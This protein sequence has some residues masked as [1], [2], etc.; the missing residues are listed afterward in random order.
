MNQS[1]PHWICGAAE[2]DITPEGSVF[3]FGYPHVPRMST[4]V[5][6]PLLSSAIYCSDGQAGVMLIANDIIWVPRSVSLRARQR[7]SESTGIPVSNIM[8]TASHTH[9]GPVATQM[10]SHSADTVVPP[11]DPQYLQHLEDR[12]VEAGIAAF[13]NARPATL[14]MAIA[15]ATGL[16]TNRHDPAGPANPKLPVLVARDAAKGDLIAIMC[17]CSMHP[18]V[19]HEDWLLISGDFPGL[20]RRQLR[21]RGFGCPFVYHMGAAGDQSPRHVVRG[22]TIAEAV[23]LGT[24]LA[25][26]I[27]GALDAAA[28]VEPIRIDCRSAKVE[29]P[30]R[31][32][33]SLQ[34]A[35]ELEAAA[36]RTWESLKASGASPADIRTAECAVFGAEETVTL[37]RAAGEGLLQQTAAECMPAEV[38]ALTIGDHTWV[39]W[40]GEVFVAFALEVMASH[41]NASVITLANGE[42]QGYLVTQA[43][44]DTHTYEAG[45]A[46]F[47]SPDG[48]Q[49]LVQTTRQLLS[50]RPT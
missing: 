42:L 28:P 6:D 48:G 1:A 5:H 9:S 46:L 26:R 11:P 36:R 39:G 23:R 7:I 44:I 13:R 35:L 21:Q 29:L 10:L 8:V 33:P 37:A 32:I 16:G 14:G 30:V 2:A 15:D 34:E 17:V 41:P 4:G 49:L 38:Q 40:P 43:A 24:L 19:L 12:I 25:D 50:Q 45:N 27:T 18:T 3:L 22:N 31:E 47:R 20:A